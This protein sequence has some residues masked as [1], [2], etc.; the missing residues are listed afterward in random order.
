[1]ADRRLAPGGSM[2]LLYDSFGIRQFQV[3]VLLWPE[4][5]S[6]EVGQLSRLYGGLNGDDL[7]TTC[8][9]RGTNGAR[10]EGEHWVY[11][12]SD[13]SIMLRCRGYSGTDELRRIIRSLL[14]NT[15]QFFAPPRLAFFVDTVRAFGLVPDDKDRDIGQVVQQRLLNRVPKAD[16]EALPGLM[17]AGL[18]LV[19]DAE[20]FHWHGDIEPPHGA[21]HML[22]LDAELIFFPA[23][24]PP[25]AVDD[26]DSIDERVIMAYNFVND[27]LRVFA[28]KVFR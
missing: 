24:E 27:D 2:T 17:G 11:D 3:D 25:T 13:G 4:I 26:L 8:E 14:A 6:F 1:M 9:L 18:R 28:S 16:R 19:G 10:Y 12:I 21:Y 15:R 22:A 5:R 23:E 7:F 20:T